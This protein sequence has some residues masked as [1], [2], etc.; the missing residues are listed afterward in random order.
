M[1]FT[2]CYIDQRRILSKEITSIATLHLQKVQADES[3][4]RG[5]PVCMQACSC[6]CHGFSLRCR[7]CPTAST[8]PVLN[9]LMHPYHTS[10]MYALS[11]LHFP[12]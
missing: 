2:R 10:F 6:R 8:V 11:L 1:F 7:K 12:Y 5:L 9:F 4:I 3:P